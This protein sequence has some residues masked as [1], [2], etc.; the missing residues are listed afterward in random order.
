MP[1]LY[2]RIRRGSPAGQR[3][4]PPAPAA[5]PAAA[6]AGREP[7]QKYLNKQTQRDAIRLVPAEQPAGKL[8]EGARGSLGHAVNGTALPW[9]PAAAGVLHRACRSLSHP[10]G[11]QFNSF[12]PLFNLNPR[13]WRALS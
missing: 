7:R 5:A 13:L 10:R 4:A 1:P 8:L 6:G 3:R 12:P 2:P 9:L 11:A